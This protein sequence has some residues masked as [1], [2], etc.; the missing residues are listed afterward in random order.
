MWRNFKNLGIRF[1]EKK[2]SHLHIWECNGLFTI[3]WLTEKWL[4]GLIVLTKRF[5]SQNLS[6]NFSATF[7]VISRM[8]WSW[9]KHNFYKKSN[10]KINSSVT[11][12]LGENFKECLRAPVTWRTWCHPSTNFRIIIVNPNFIL[13][14]FIQLNLMMLSVVLHHL[15]QPSYD[16]CARAVLEKRYTRCCAFSVN[17]Y[18]N[19]RNLIK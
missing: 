8:Y 18:L 4:R 1:V 6:K 17:F 9:K 5:S 10:I 3:N 19:V 16:I 13:F 12:Q 11:D 7:K 15:R 2:T 14:V